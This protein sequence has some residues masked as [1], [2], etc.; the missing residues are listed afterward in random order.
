MNNQTELERFC[1]VIRT[2]STDN[3]NAINQLYQ[4]SNITNVVSVLR[5]EL[6]SLIRVIYILSI[7]DLKYRNELINLSLRNERWRKLN[8][9]G[10]ITDRDMVDLGN[11]L[12]GWTE[13][14][15]KFGCAFIH[16]SPFHDYRESDPMTGLSEKER[17]DIVRYLRNYHYGP[18]NDEP[19][20]NEI[21]HFLPKVFNKISS[22]LE[23]YL[24]ML[25]SNSFLDDE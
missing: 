11:Q 8:D 14:V 23:C 19:S 3:K 18:V 16:L 10:F 20:F 15:Y 2:R 7:R 1:R 6:D 22:N 25:E 4:S 12:N 5:Q 9:K 21:I 13:Y 17:E 24:V